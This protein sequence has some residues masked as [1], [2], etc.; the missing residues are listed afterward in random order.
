MFPAASTV[1]PEAATTPKLNVFVLPRSAALTRISGPVA[2]YEKVS[3]ACEAARAY[4]VPFHWKRSTA[5]GT[6]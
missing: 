1:E 5:P 2:V 6:S 3:D 4:V